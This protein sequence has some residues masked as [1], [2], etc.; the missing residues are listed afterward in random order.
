MGGKIGIFEKSA[1]VSSNQYIFGSC[2]VEAIKVVLNNKV[3][4]FRH[5]RILRG[6]KIKVSFLPFFVEFF[7][8]VPYKN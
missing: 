8:V 4:E 7:F 6:F 1:Y 2:I 5:K 3:S